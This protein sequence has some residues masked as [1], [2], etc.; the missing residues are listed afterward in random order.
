MDKNVRQRM[1][2]LE[3]ETYDLEK[4]IFAK[5]DFTPEKL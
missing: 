2:S 1:S 4:R 3:H 5:L